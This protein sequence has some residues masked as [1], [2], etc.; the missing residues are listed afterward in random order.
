[1]YTLEHIGYDVKVLNVHLNVHYTRSQI[2]FHHIW[3]AFAFDLK[4]KW[5]ILFLTIRMFNFLS[6]LNCTFIIRQF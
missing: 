6:M 2:I 5:L 4:K 1:M 3:S